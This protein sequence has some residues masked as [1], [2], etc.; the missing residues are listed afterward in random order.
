MSVKSPAD[1]FD[2]SRSE[3]GISND[4]AGPQGTL[5]QQNL[6]EVAPKLFSALESPAE[7]PNY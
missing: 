6:K 3:V 1:L 4:A 2:L 7:F 5:E